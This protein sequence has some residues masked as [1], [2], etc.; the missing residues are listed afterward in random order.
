MKIGRPIKNILDQEFNYWKVLEFSHVQNGN[1]CWK[2]QCQLCGDIYPVLAT[3]LKS[4][5]STKCKKCANAERRQHYARA[6]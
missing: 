6:I 2:C 3:N 4:G 5:D 1:A